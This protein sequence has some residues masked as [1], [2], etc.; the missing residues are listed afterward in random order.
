[1]LF[2]REKII[3]ATIFQVKRLVKTKLT[4]FISENRLTSIL[5]PILFGA[6]RSLEAHLLWEQGVGGSNPLAPTIIKNF[7]IMVTVYILKGESGKRYVGITND[8]AR[9]LREHRLGKSKG[10]QIIGDFT[11]IYRE[12]FPDHKSARAREV[13]LKSGKGRE[14][15]NYIELKSEPAQA[16]KA[17][18]L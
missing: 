9:R 3:K 16:D 8:L 2:V 10:S 5:H 12:E 13:H 1:M 6:W 7:H 17:S 15:L 11:L 14:W 18:P 4:C